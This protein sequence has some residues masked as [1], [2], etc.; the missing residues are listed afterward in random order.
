MSQVIRKEESASDVIFG[1][2]F[3]VGFLI[4]V[5]GLIL[6]YI[7]IVE[8]TVDLTFDFMGFWDTLRSLPQWMQFVFSGLLIMGA[9]VIV[10]TGKWMI[11]ELVNGTFGREKD[12]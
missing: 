5:F 11:E 1:I 2:G 9:A 6:M 8:N 7:P 12:E 4:A 3:K 10:Y